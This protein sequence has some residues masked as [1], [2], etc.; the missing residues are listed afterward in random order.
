MHLSNHGGRYLGDPVF[1]AVLAELNWRS[2]VVFLHPATPPSSPTPGLPTF[3][4][5]YPFETTRAVATLLRTGSLERHA[6]VRLVLAHAGGAVPYLVG[7]LALGQAPT[8]ARA[9]IERL[10]GVPVGE[11]LGRL[12]YDTALSTGR[13]TLR[14]LDALAGPERTVFGSDYPYAPEP[15]IERTVREVATHW[16]GEALGRIF[17]RNVLELFPHLEGNPSGATESGATLPNGREAEGR[18][19]RSVLPL[20]RRCIPRGDREM[21][22]CRS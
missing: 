21:R 22:K 11:A 2:A 17:H 15:L 12:Y 10:A 19:R 6:N 1:D 3:L 8:R 20:V 4:L 5:D 9:L 7:R 18:L 14:A 16:H 13:P